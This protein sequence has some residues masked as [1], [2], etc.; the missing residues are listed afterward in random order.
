MHAL[1]HSG[2]GSKSRPHIRWFSRRRIATDEGGT[3]MTTKSRP[4]ARAFALALVLALPLLVVHAQPASPFRIGFLCAN[5]ASPVDEALRQLG[6]VEGRNAVFEVRTTQGR[7]D[8]AREQ[9]ADLVRAKV[10]VIVAYT[11]LHAFAAKQATSTIPIVVGFT[12]GAVAT[13]L[14]PSLAR[15]GGN[16]T[17]IESLAP[18]LDM[19]RMDLLRQIV[20]ALSSVAALYNVD[21]RGSLV[22][23]KH[24]QE[25]GRALGVRVVPLEVRTAADYDTVFTPIAGDPVGAL[26]MINDYLT[27]AN[28]KRVADFALASRTPTVCAL[29]FQAHDGCLV[30]Y[31]PPIDELTKVVAHQV[32]RIL[33]G[34]KPADIPSEQVARF[35]L[36]VNLKTARGLG[37]SIPSSVLL[38][39]DAVIE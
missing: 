24:T 2:I 27:L 28:W 5:D 36:V 8:R 15:P 32:D 6:Y 16:V 12:H 1:G 31:G 29:S 9:A 25:A 3:E 34:A 22:H 23:L 10:D 37:I 26:L 35:E 7:P 4:L 33:K 38:R 18:E 30:S 14:V 21:D 11:N 19:K 17:G 13:G 20:P 39:A